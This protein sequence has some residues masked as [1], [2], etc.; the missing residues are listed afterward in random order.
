MKKTAGFL[1]LIFFLLFHT[2]IIFA[3]ENEQNWNKLNELAEQVLQL[4]KQRKYEEARQI[5]ANFS[6][7]FLKLL[8]EQKLTLTQIKTVI[9]AYEQADEALTSVKMSDEERQNK[10]LQFRLTVNAVTNKHH[11]M[12]LD[13]K[14][15]VLEPLTKAIQAIRKNE[16]HQFQMHVNEFLTNYEIIRPSLI[17]SLPE[18]EYERYNSYVKYIENNRHNID[19]NQIIMIQNEFNSL[20][21]NMKFSN[22][23]PELIGL[24]YIIGGIIS[25]TLIY[26]GWRK[27]KGEKHK[28]QMK[29]LD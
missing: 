10:L 1:I 7:D 16:P 2:T 13:A 24:M 20:F 29:D 22:A 12:W 17:I 23:E 28:K 19:Q 18:Q 25:I 15:L 3:K 21:E 8:P 27:Y 6:T 26:V 4:G 5:I 14:N 11:P 9:T